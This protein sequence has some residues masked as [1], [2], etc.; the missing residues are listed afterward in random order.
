MATKPYTAGY[1]INH[2]DLAE[3]R[4]LLVKFFRALAK[5]DARRDRAKV[6]EGDWRKKARKRILM[7]RG[8]G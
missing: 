1:T 2:P 3:A 8:K 6:L 5:A 4:N 7:P